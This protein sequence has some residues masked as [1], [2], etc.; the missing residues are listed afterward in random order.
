V[1]AVALLGA[2]APSGAPSSDELDAWPEGFPTAFDVT[3]EMP[4][5]EEP[6]GELPDAMM[7]YERV[8]LA[9]DGEE[10]ASGE[11]ATVDYREEGLDVDCGD[12][13]DNGTGAHDLTEPPGELTAT[14]EDGAQMTLVPERQI[15]IYG[16]YGYPQCFEQFGSYEVVFSSGS[17]PGVKRGAYHLLDEVLTLD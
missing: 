16:Y 10:L 3:F 11:L 17:S 15:V 7:I 14:F 6:Y 13:V 5:D 2:C 12:S 8:M 9:A 1:I 4:H